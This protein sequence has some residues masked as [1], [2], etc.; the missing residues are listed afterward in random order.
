[1]CADSKCRRAREY[2]VMLAIMLPL[3]ILPLLSIFL[4]GTSKGWAC[5]GHL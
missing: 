5:S 1:M 2:R 4:F 3:V